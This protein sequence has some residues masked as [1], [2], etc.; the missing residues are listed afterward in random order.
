[1]NIISDLFNFS[2]NYFFN[3]TGDL[4]I[5]I[6]LLTLSV[7]LLL[8]PLS[9]K[10]KVSI[11]GQQKLSQDLENLKEKYKNNKKRL[12]IETQKYYKENA[13]GMAGCLVGL[14]QIPIVFTL[15]NVILKMPMNAGTMVI[16][17]VT[18]LKMTDSFFI[19]PIIY[20]IS[21]MLP[22]LLPNIPFLKIATEA[23]VNKANILIISFVSILVSLKAPVA[24]GLY[25]IAS[26]LF[27]F[28]E[29]VAFRLYW[30]RK[31]VTP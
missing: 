6:I 22:N 29:E 9:F 20:I 4:G 7:R 10:Q 8:M 26:S 30:R 18:S 31:I 19:V 1:M 12:D 16:P 5:A 28:I 11:Q 27:S 15:Y 24:L 17:W 23:K 13:K 25:F 21:T 3:I 2:L 14:L